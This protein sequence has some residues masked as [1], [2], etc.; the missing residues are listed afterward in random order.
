MFKKT[1]WVSLAVFC[2]VCAA[3]SLIELRNALKARDASVEAYFKR[4]DPE[5]EKGAEAEKGTEADPEAEKGAEAEYE[6]EKDAAAEP[7]PETED[8]T[9]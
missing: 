9:E 2:V 1:A 8:R 5:A 7:D 4:V 3:E 6:P